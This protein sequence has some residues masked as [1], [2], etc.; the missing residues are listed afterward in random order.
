MKKIDKLVLD[1]FLGPF[2]ITF[3][4]VVFILLNINMLKYFDDIIGKGLDGLV[5]GQLFFYFAVFTVPTAMPLAVLLSSLIAFGNLG[6]HFELSAIKSAGISLVRALRPIF[7]FV[8]LLTVLAF[9][10]NNNL[11]PKAALEAYSLLY[12]IKQK[13][14]ALELREGVFYHGIDNISIKVNH[15]FP[16]DDKALKEVIVYDHRKNDGNKEVMI[17]DSGRMY[18]ILG[19][20][21]LKFELFNGYRYTEGTSNEREMTGQRNAN[22]QALSRSKFAKSQVVF[23]LSSFALQSTDKKWFQGN[24]IMRNM[25]EL[26]SDIDSINVEVLNQQLNYYQNKQAFFTFY[27][28]HDS[29]T[30]PPEIQAYKIYRDSINRIPYMNKISPVAT[31][32]G[33]TVKKKTGSDSLNA[34]KE[35]AERMKIKNEKRRLLL[36]ARKKKLGEKTPPHGPVRTARKVAVN[37]DS[38]SLARIDSVFNMPIG[39]DVIQGAT[40]MA[41]QVKSQIMN[42]NASVEN[43]EKDLKEFD[44]QWNKIPSSSF[45]CIAMFLIGAPLGAIIKRGGL[46]VPFLVSIFFFIVFY[47]LSMQGEKLAKQGTVSVAVGVWLSDFVLLV[48]GALFLRQARADA[49]LFEADFYLVAIDKLK[50]WFARKRQLRAQQA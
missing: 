28:R 46:G 15:K 19:E 29:L 43:Y 49:R 9:Y 30:M 21:Y 1:A 40:N 10:I 35:R 39:R 33:D 5:L 47:V 48:V 27:Q 31:T 8:L 22:P 2:L 45:A 38:A 3:L 17:A 4:V 25:S 20:R 41:R 44:I 18:T 23:D 32:P 36:S 6:E 13:K 12:D 14:P 11:V 7:F 16:K 42:A 37:F 24:R 50:R 34:E 26:S